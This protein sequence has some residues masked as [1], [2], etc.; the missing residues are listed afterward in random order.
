MSTITISHTHADGTLIE[1]TERGDG[2][3]T[4]LKANG[5]KWF[6]TLGL[7]GIPHSRDRLPNDWKIGRIA[8]ALRAAGYDVDTDIDRS[9]RD[10]ADV[11][12]DKAI[13]AQ[14][15]AEA[16][17]DKADRKHA[18]ADAAEAAH[19]R[20]VEMV[21]PG[22]EPIKLG[23]HSEHRHRRAIEKAHTSLGKVVQ[24]DRDADDAAHRAALAAVATD[25]RN[26]PVTVA[27]RIDKFKAEQRADQRALEGHSRTVADL[28]ERGRIVD[29]FPAA[30]GEY[31]A[32]LIERMAERA[33]QITYWTQVRE[34]QIAT[35]QTANYG[36]TTIAKGDAVRV[37]GSWYRVV[38]VNKKTVSVDVSRYYQA[39]TRVMTDTTP[40]HEISDHKAK[41]DAADLDA[42]G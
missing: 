39:A 5:C 34:Q 21:P 20:A 40:Y 8:D 3:N 33:D 16:L 18:A 19:R 7:W 14:A 38:R 2:T 11:E 17:A 27:N 41:T 42:T 37:R 15:R 35:G 10:T 22:G 6:R 25:R 29:S 28:G 30:T 4:I 24:A 12:A 26:S 36:P 31:R 23:H 32:R 13:R 1:G 9:Y